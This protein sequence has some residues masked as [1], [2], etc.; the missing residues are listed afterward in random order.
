MTNIADR[1]RSVRAL[2][3]SINGAHH[4]IEEAIHKAAITI[5]GATLFRR[6]HGVSP[7]LGQKPLDDLTMGLASLVEARGAV[8]TAH[9]GLTELG[10]QTGILTTDE[11]GLIHKPPLSEVVPL[12]ERAATA[13]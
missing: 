13:A 9:E 3:G 6:E 4:M 7:L 10:L 11:G 12:P 2:A 1:Q 8:I 5:A